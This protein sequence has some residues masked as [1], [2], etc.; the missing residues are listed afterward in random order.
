MSTNNFKPFGVGVGAN[1]TPQAD[2]EALAALIT[3]FQSGKANSAQVNKAIRQATVMASVIG[4]F[5]ANYSGSDVLDNG[6]S[7][8]LLSNLITALKSNSSND[9]LQITNNLVEIKNAGTSAQTS[10]RTNLGLGTAATATVGTGTNQIPNMGSFTSSLS[11]QGWQR[12]PSSASPT[13]YIIIQWGRVPTVP[14]AGY[15]GPLTFL[16]PYPNRA[17]RTY[18]HA[19]YTPGGGLSGLAYSACDGYNASK[20]GVTYICSNSGIGGSYFSIGY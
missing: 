2:Y 7:A 20:T 14:A 5:I 16:I 19:D 17:M 11:E 10:A 6:D 3:G 1:V 15:D 13:G 4:Q 8:T 18:V 9:F 12:V